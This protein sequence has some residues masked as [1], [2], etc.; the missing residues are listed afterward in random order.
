MFLF[1]WHYKKFKK[2]FPVNLC[3]TCLYVCTECVCLVPV[4]AREGIRSSGTGVK[5]YRW[6]WVAIWM[7][8]I[9]PG[10]SAKGTNAPNLSGPLCKILKSSFC[11][12]LSRK[13]SHLEVLFGS[14]VLQVGQDCQLRSSTSA[15]LSSRGWAGRCLLLLGTG[16]FLSQVHLL[17]QLHFL[18]NWMFFWI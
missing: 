3:L 7:I 10:S 18:L 14:R 15:G 13:L 9:K 11:T 4:E 2:W 5:S 12:T 1:L 17:R 6:L 16:Y 8:G